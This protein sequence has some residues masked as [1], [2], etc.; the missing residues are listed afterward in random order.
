MQP[1]FRA[2]EWITERVMAELIFRTSKSWTIARFRSAT[3]SNSHM[4]ER[5]S[6][7]LTQRIAT[8]PLRAMVLI[9]FQGVEFVSSQVIS[10][11][12]NADKNVCKKAGT[13]KL[14]HVS[15]K[16]REALHITG[17]L[18][19]F[20]IVKSESAVLGPPERAKA[21]VSATELG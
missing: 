4:I 8:L 1:P 15:P 19:Q 18:D 12:L 11:L 14:C 3:L 20:T 10:L 13:L 5:A 16:I 9:D 21:R 17:L 2:D 7:E 6:D